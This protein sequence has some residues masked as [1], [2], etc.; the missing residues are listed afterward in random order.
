MTKETTIKTSK[1][2]IIVQI[3][4]LIV[5]IG[6]LLATISAYIEAKRANFLTNIPML[7]VDKDIGFSLKPHIDTTD[8]RNIPFE[9]SCD[10]RIRI[11]GTTPAIDVSCQGGFCNAPDGIPWLNTIDTTITNVL[12]PGDIM[13]YSSSHK[14]KAIMFDSSIVSA[15]NFLDEKGIDVSV[16][17]N[18]EYETQIGQP[19]YFK[20][21][22]RYKDIVGNKYIYLVCFQ[23]TRSEDDIGIYCNYRVLYSRLKLVKN[24]SDNL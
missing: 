22:C 23:L 3:A 18:R 9:I 17:K 24:Y 10:Y 11:V 1:L 8:V 7:R 4:A 2:T 12:F 13:N 16:A 6:L 19:F 5:Y 20:V 15:M 14:L 21:R